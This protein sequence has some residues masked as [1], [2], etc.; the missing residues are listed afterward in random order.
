MDLPF[1]TEQLMSDKDYKTAVFRKLHRDWYWMD[2][3]PPENPAC[4]NRKAD[5]QVCGCAVDGLGIHK[6]IC[7]F[8]GG[9]MRRHN[10]VV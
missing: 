10:A 3:P 8:G 9:V 6:M 1:K 4:G 2:N 7:K 5:G